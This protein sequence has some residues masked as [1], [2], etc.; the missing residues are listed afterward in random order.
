MFINETVIKCVTPAVDDDPESI[1]REA[2]K[3]TVAMNGVDHD[4]MASQIEF[5]FIGT[6]TYLVFWPL[7]IGGLLITLLITAL[8]LCCA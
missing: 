1:Y 8:I 4:E 6:G 7:I 3:L 2:V 5:T